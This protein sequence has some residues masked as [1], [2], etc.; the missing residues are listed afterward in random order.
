MPEKISNWAGNYT[1]SATGVRYPTTVEQ[2]QERVRQSKKIRA[3]G[4]R[5]SFNGVADAGGEFVSLERFEP[6]M[7]VDRERMTVTVNANAKYGQFC[8]ELDNEGYALHNLASLPH[9]SVAG[10]CATSTHGS[11]DGNGSLASAVVGLELVDGRGEVVVLAGDELAGAVVGLGGLGIVTKVTLKI[12][13]AYDMGQVVYENLPVEQLDAHF[14]E[15]ESSAYSVSLFTDWRGD[16]INQVWLKSRVREGEEFGIGSDFFGATPAPTNRHP[17]VEISPVNCTE[18]MGVP[19]PWYERLPHFRM[20]F[21]PSSGEELQT[22]YL[23]PRQYALEAFHAIGSLSE[24]ISPLLQIS[25]IRTIAADDLWMSPFYKK[26]C[27]GFH[28]TWV[29]DWGAV[30]RLLPLIEER[31]APF[32]ARP[33]WGKLFTMPPERVRSLYERRQEFRG[34]LGKYDPEGKFRNAFLDAYVFGDE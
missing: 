14:D 22:E 12:E 7:V 27:V 29:K 28:F 20:D 21:T 33:H 18:Q 25:E 8:R 13:P 32:D 10:A 26:A 1:Y 15:I 9:I 5:H 24:R 4:S 11:G 23:V 3:L 34:L 16:T 17:I 19:G 6:L 2:V 31:L 30:K